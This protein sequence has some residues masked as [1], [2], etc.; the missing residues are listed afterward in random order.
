MFKFKKLKT[1]LIVIIGLLIFIFFT[2]IHMF[3]SSHSRNIAK[4]FSFKETETTAKGYG[5]YVRAEIEIALDSART[6]EQTFEGMKTIKNLDR[7]IFNNILK[8]II[9]RNPDF[10]DVWTCWEPDALVGKDQEFIN[11]IGHDKTGKFIPKWHRDDNK[12]NVKPLLE[13]DIPGAGDYYLLCKNSN[14]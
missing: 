1:K 7:E 6:L 14:E 5:E 4:E 10:I 8:N 2:I 3:F 9:K 13:Y 11:A 12:I